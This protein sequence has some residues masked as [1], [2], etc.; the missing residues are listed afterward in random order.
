MRRS[1]CVAYAR[2]GA[3][4]ALP[5]CIAHAGVSAFNILCVSTGTVDAT[6]LCTQKGTARQ[7]ARPH[8]AG[9]SSGGHTLWRP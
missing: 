7:L 1:W 6:S 2:A 3:L 9:A 5:I 4:Q 8:L